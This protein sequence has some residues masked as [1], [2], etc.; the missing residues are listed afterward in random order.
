[1]ICDECKC[2]IKWFKCLRPSVK[3]TNQF[4]H[5]TDYLT[6]CCHPCMQKWACKNNRTLL[7]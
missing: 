2:T 6:F 3:V 5:T 1:M 4:G 7:D